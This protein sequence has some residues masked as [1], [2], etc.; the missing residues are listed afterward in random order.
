[1]RWGMSLYCVALLSV[2]SLCQTVAAEPVAR[3]AIIIDDLGN[4]QM[5]GRQAVELP[6]NL[7]FAML[8]QRPYS[9][10]LAHA[11]H[12]SGREVMLHLP[13]QASDGRAMGP[14]GLELGMQREQFTRVVHDNIAAIPHLAGVNNHM[15]SLLTREPRVMRWLMQELSCIG[16][17]YFVDSRTDVRTVAAEEARLAGLAHA[18]RDVFLDNLI[19][20]DAIRRQFGRLLTR[21][22]ATGSAIGI[23]HP[24]P[25]TLA[26]LAE[27]L[28]TLDGQRIELV[29]VSRLVTSER[30][31]KTWHACS[32]P[33]PTVAKN[34]KP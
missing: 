29:P 23:G 10:E 11:V 2:L 27:L 4:S 15:G 22:R 12:A 5:L 17:L 16:G 33:L 26:V 18:R 3:I 19:E 34:S 28:P 24:Y 14:G 8:P 20:P 25:E 31:E 30:S 21:A 1:M 13:M 6:G 9:R 7:T 32:S